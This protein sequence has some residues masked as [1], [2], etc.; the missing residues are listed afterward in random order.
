VSEAH[1]DA[2]G[3]AGQGTAGAASATSASPGAQ[4]V[5]LPT[6]NGATTGAGGAAA[7][8]EGFL[9]LIPEAIRSEAYF[10]DIKDVPNLATKAYNQAK[11]IG[12]NP[13]SLVAI[14]GPDDA[15]G[16]SKVYD[17]LGRPANANEYGFAAPT[18]PE[19]LSLD[20]ELLN[21]FGAKAHELGLSKKQAA[22]LYEWWNQARSG[23]WTQIQA[24]E[25]AARSAAEAAMK[26][27]F[28]Q[29]FD[30]K[31][32]L[33]DQTIDALDRE[34]KTNGELHEAVKAMPFEARLALSKLF[35]HV[36][37]MLKEDSVVGGGGQG[38]EGAVTPTEARQQING[39]LADKDFTAAYYDKRAPGHQ[40]A[41][42]RMLKLH[43]FLVPPKP[44]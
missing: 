7:G 29:A 32:K 16:W 28:G 34:M 19:G 43:G 9:A 10:K 26:A 4:S 30:D 20:P 39:L 1:A 12:R 14:P 38:G 21:G 31:I 22:S 3:S 5:S 40:A 6:G 11:L 25:T 13:D 24:S 8:I 36:A 42:E 23:Q 35:L 17:Q 2:G 37:P 15:E 33:V 44:A 27:E 18:L 41:V